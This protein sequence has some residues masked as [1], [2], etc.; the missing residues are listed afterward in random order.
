LETVVSTPACLGRKDS[1]LAVSV[2]DISSMWIDS[3][4]WYCRDDKA[5]VRGLEECPR[6]TTE[7][8]NKFE[9]PGTFG[10]VVAV[11]V[12]EHIVG[13]DTWIPKWWSGLDPRE[14]RPLTVELFEVTST[15]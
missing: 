12:V 11:V 1:E 13:L 7:W 5:E 14:Q 2:V 6:Q 15:T 4:L 8:R 3:K 9:P 10:L